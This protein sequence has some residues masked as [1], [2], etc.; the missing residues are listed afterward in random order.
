MFQQL[1]FVQVANSVLWCWQACDF[2]FIIVWR[3]LLLAAGVSFCMFWSNAAMISAVCILLG[4]FA[5]YECIWF[6]HFH[7][8]WLCF[9]KSL[10]TEWTTS[11]ATFHVV[12]WLIS[13]DQIMYIM[14]RFC[15][16][17][18]SC[19]PTFTFQRFEHYVGFYSMQMFSCVFLAVKA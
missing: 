19:N 18:D 12:V 11:L 15:R 5:A 13:E 2:M 10:R 17:I 3:R 1:S 16:I 9:C 14:Q 8:F 4:H 6:T 7:S